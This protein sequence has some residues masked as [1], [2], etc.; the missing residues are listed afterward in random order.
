MEK[1]KMTEMPTDTADEVRKTSL[2][3]FIFRAVGAF[4]LL[5]VLLGILFLWGYHAYLP[6][7]TW[8]TPGNREVLIY[9]DAVYHLGGELG[10]AGYSTKDYTFG[11]MLGQVKPDT[12]WAIRPLLKDITP[13]VLYSVKNKQ[14]CLLLLREDGKYDV[15][16]LNVD[17]G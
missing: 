2:V 16:C 15:Y 9:E 14:D 3:R 1:I 6:V 13:D 4:L 8:Q 17:K 10:D 12:G 11:K 7:A 5:G